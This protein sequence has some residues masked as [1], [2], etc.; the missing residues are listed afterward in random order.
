M[1][2]RKVL[3]VLVCIGNVCRRAALDEQQHDQESLAKL[4]LAFNLAGRSEIAGGTAVKSCK[5]RLQRASITCSEAKDLLYLPEILQS[6]PFLNA[7]YE[8]IQS[9]PS[10]LAQ[11]CALSSP[12]KGMISHLSLWEK[13]KVLRALEVAFLAHHGQTRRSGEPFVMHPIAVAEDLCSR[14]MDVESI[15]AGLLHDT[16]EDTE[17][18]FGEI[19]QMFG[20]TVKAI[21][22]GETKVS[23]LPKMVRSAYVPD[24]LEQNSGPQDEQAENLRSMFIA[25]ADDY[26]IVAVKLADRLHNM[27]TLM[28]MPAKKQQII[29][30]ETLQMFVPL[31]HRLGMWY[32]KEQLADLSFK[33][34]YPGEYNS[35]KAFIEKCENA[36]GDAIHQT[37][38]QLQEM[39]LVGNPNQ[40]RY[41]A[42]DISYRKKSVYSTWRKMQRR[43]CRIEQIKDILALRVVL[44]VKPELLAFDDEAFFCYE[45][46]SKVHS[47][48]TPCPETMKDYIAKPKPNGYKSLHTTVLVDETQPLEIQIRTSGMHEVAER[49]AAAHWN[50]DNTDDRHV[51][52][53]LKVQAENKHLT[54]PEFVQRVREELQTSSVFVCTRDGKILSLKSGSTVSDAAA[55]LNVSVT[56]HEFKVNNQLVHHDRQLMNGD[57]ISFSRSVPL[58]YR[59]YPETYQPSKASTRYERCPQCMPVP[60][61]KLS[62]CR[63]SNSRKPM[64]IHRGDI[65]CRWKQKQLAVQGYE[66][67]E[68]SFW[69]FLTPCSNNEQLEEEMKSLSNNGYDVQIIVFVRDRHGVLIDISRV[70]ME[71][72]DIMGVRAEIREP[73]QE[74]A[75]Q[76]TI[77]VQNVIQ[78]NTLIE[79]VE[80]A[81]DTVLVLRDNIDGLM[82]ESPIDFWRLAANLL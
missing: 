25:M 15:V 26:R 51:V 29:S 81:S 11:F 20:P 62:V 6:A 49:G 7:K 2:V 50:K 10:P 12:L 38:Q 14:G 24:S 18:T 66:Q 23:K 4:L 46:L 77:R 31:A 82:D 75:L 53:W 74:A 59:Q 45:V 1:L 43:N 21:V 73:N 67:L 61:D 30:R 76:Y 56:A 19:E 28:H 36:S 52:P 47:R 5:R 79:A 68:E 63:S 22:L 17:L 55:R 37:T 69:D 16:V 64:T 78:L 8:M 33:Y 3:L 70:I 35:T 80:N 42:V 48:W 60:G 34:L 72:G 71:H 27:K 65:D 54:A 13:E 39:L 40:R 41:T 58:S 32:Y 44:H 57:L 9:D